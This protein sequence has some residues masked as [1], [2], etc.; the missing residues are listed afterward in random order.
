M[1]V[2]RCLLRA[3]EVGMSLES[4]VE[5]EEMVATAGVVLRSLARMVDSIL[6][7]V[8]VGMVMVVVGM[9][10]VVVVVGMVMM[11]CMVGIRYLL[12]K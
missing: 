9:V 1:M 8:V 7:L 11:V 6:V 3:V 4:V 10:M 2:V 5:V 12:L